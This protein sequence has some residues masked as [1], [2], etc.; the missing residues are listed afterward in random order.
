MINDIDTMYKSGCVIISFKIKTI[1]VKVS[2]QGPITPTEIKM[3]LTG[4]I[5]GIPPMVNPTLWC[6]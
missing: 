4:M 3:T 5:T 1:S 6:T 2:A